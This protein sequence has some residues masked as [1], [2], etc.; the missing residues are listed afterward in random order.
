MRSIDMRRAERSDGQSAGTWIRLLVP[1]VAGEPVSD[2]RRMAYTFYFAN[3]I[4]LGQHIGSMSLINPDVTP[5]VLRPP[6]GEWVAITDDPR[7]NAT[8]R[9]AASPAPLSDLTGWFAVESC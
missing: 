9:L 5:Q 8:L 2:G 7:S 3:L 4:C 1:I 6:H